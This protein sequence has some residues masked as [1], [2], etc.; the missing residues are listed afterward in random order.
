MA[1]HKTRRVQKYTWET[2]VLERL[3]LLMDQLHLI[4]QQPAFIFEIRSNGLRR[5]FL[6]IEYSS[7]NNPA[8]LNTH[9]YF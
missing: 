7:M 3:I 6:A 4:S 9:V 8:N 5:V 1:D 2:T